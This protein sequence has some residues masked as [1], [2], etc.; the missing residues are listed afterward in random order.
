MRL[1]DALARTRDALRTAGL[2]S[3]DADARILLEEASGLSRADTVRDPDRDLD[4]G[5]LTRLH[6]WTVE[7]CEHVPLQYITGIADFCGR[8]FRVTPDV[9]IPRPET[10]LVT[11][12]AIA[13]WDDPAR[14]DHPALD[15]CTG[16]GA[17][18]ATLALERPGRRVVATDLS[19][20][21]LAVA[22]RNV[23]EL[24]ATHVTFHDGDLFAA[25]PAGAGGFGLL[26]SNPPYVEAGVIPT[27]P[28]DVRDHEPHLAL[29]GG[30]DGLDVVRRI[31]AGAPA[32]LADGAALV[33]E[34]G[35]TQGDTV[36]ELARAA[37]YYSDA[38]I[39]PDLAGRSRILTAIRR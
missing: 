7:R 9:L 1:A 18:A 8:R 29:D 19:R 21:A 12:T 4:V 11:E 14:R 3:P 28:R 6:A 32:V 10:E 38:R 5:V 39:L 31:L 2:E 34:I 26:V 33:I 37:S 15:L 20:A 13:L 24:E 30:A 27:L 23:Q 16:S 22:R 35:D 25:L 17:I 36:L